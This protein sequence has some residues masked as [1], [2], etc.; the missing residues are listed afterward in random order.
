M[1]KPRILVSSTCEDLYVIREQLRNLIE[2]MGYESVLSEEGDIYYSPDLHVHLSCIREVPNCDM[3]ILIVG[4]KFGSEFVSSPDKSI[5]QVEHDTAY[6]STIPIFAFIEHRVLHDYST[7]RRLMAQ[8]KV[9]GNE[10]DILLSKI[11]FG[12][13][14]DIKSGLPPIAVPLTELVSRAS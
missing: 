14:A 4:N 12:S 6:L 1:A 2:E 10:P 9:E 3:V 13:Q 7:Y 8:D 11:P 5:T